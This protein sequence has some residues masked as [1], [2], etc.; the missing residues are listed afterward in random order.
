MDFTNGK[1]EPGDVCGCPAQRSWLLPLALL[2]VL[3]CVLIVR[4]FLT[5]AL[6]ANDVQV[7]SQR[8]EPPGMN[9]ASA[10]AQFPANP[11][12][13]KTVSLEIDFGNGAT[14][15][16]HT[17]PWHDGMTV[18]DLMES[19]AAYRPGL[20]FSSRGAGESAYLT[21][22]DGI[23]NE[24]HGGRNWIFYLRDTPSPQGMGRQR[25]EPGDAI[26]WKYE[27]YE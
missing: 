16:F 5:N 21:A 20:R 8:R 6:P 18:M 25:L 9:N 15:K 22:I 7:D 11:P 14:R 24:N 26:L 17:L 3:A 2:V 1:R 23:T 13:G 19:A 10:P 27:P 4:Y 12:D